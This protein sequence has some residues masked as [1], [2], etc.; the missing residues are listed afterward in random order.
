MNA[1]F[2]RD[3]V[4]FPSETYITSLP[5]NHT[6]IYFREKSIA[7][8]IPQIFRM[9]GAKSRIDWIFFLETNGA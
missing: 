2:L 6:R 9:P 4:Y 7:I 8:V 1:A 3:R 5:E